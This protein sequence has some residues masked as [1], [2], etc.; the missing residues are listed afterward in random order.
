MPDVVVVD[1]LLPG[2]NGVDLTHEIRKH[3]GV[4]ITCLSA[5]GDERKKNDAL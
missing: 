3:N 5:V 1:I 4:P 2:M